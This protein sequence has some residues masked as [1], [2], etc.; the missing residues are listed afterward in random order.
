MEVNNLRKRLR[1]SGDPA[2]IEVS[3]LSNIQIDKLLT[4]LK[5]LNFND[6]HRSEDLDG[7]LGN[8]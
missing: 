6:R 1:H 2:L 4:T 5:S 8:S 3:K 7:E